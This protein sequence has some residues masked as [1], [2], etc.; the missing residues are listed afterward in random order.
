[1]SSHFAKPEN[2]LSKAQTLVSIGK[3][4]AALKTLQGILSARRYRLWT[5]THEEIMYLY[6]Q[7][8]VGLRRN[9]KDALLQYRMI[10]QPTQ[11]ASLERVMRRYQQ[12]A[13]E[14]ANEAQAKAA[15]ATAAESTV[16]IDVDDLEEDSPESI[17]LAAMSGEGT[18]ERLD[19]QILT[20]WV[21]YLW[22]CY[23]TILE[24][25]RNNG[26]LEL[27]YHQTARAAFNFCKRFQRNMEFRRL[28]EILRNHL[29]TITKFQNQSNA[30]DLNS[31]ETQKLYLETRFQ[32]LKMAADLELW[33]E[34]YR[35]IEDIHENL[36]ASGQVEPPPELMKT[37]YEK[38]SQIFWASS[39][40][41]FHAYSLH[42]CYQLSA[43]ESLA[44]SS[45]LSPAQR[46][47]LASSVVLSALII[48]GNNSSLDLHDLDAI[49]GVEHEG[50]MRLAQL[51]GFKK[52]SPSRA[53]IIAA[54]QQSGVFQ[55]ANETVKTIFRLLE[56]Q[57]GPLTLYAQLQPLFATLRSDASLQ[58]YVAPLEQ[59][60]ILRVLQ[61]LS[62]V[63]KSMRIDKFINLVPSIGNIYAL[64]RLI[65]SGIT[66]EL[67]NLRFDHR[68]MTLIF[69]E[70]DLEQTKLKDQL[71]Q[72]SRKFIS[73]AHT[74]DAASASPADK[75]KE[76]T[77]V[78]KIIQTN[79]IEEHEN[80]FLRQ[81]LIEKR[82]QELE[83]AQYEKEKRLADEKAA[84]Q[85]ARELEEKRRLQEESVKREE[86]RL[87]KEQF[88]RELRQKQFLADEMK[89]KLNVVN[90]T[91]S[92]STAKA[93]KMI[94]ALTSDLENID[95]VQLMR[96]QEEILR[97][98]QREIERRRKESSRRIDYTVRA[99]RAEERDMLVAKMDAQ[100]EEEK[101]QFEAD[102]A[103]YLEADKAAHAK[104]LQDKARLCG[105]MTKEK[106][107][108]FEKLMQRRQSIYDVE[109][110]KQDE[111]LAI[112]AERRRAAE[113][114]R[115][116]EEEA[117]EREREAEAER[118]RKK[119]EEEDRREAE[120]A[121]A[122]K[123]RE[124]ERLER[125]RKEN[126]I[127]QQRAK[128]EEEAEQRER[129]R[130]AAFTASSQPRTGGW[131]RAA[132]GDRERERERERDEPRPERDLGDFRSR[133]APASGE[134]PPRADAPRWGRRDERPENRDNFRRDERP[135]NRDNFRRDERSENRDN[136][137]R[138]DRGGERDSFR[139]DDRDRGDF[140][141][142]DRDRGDFRRDG[143]PRDNFRRDD[144]E[145]GDFRRGGD[146][147]EPPSRDSF[148]SRAAPSSRDAPNR[149]R[150]WG[151]VRQGAPVGGRSDNRD[152]RRRD[153]D[154][155]KPQ[156]SP[157]PASSS[158]D[159]DDGF[160]EVKKGAG[161]R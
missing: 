40:F 32:Q 111:R 66:S 41:L 30:I 146:D 132:G 148:G 2:A 128:L 47:D 59:L 107:L 1:M 71:V 12:T 74:L 46:T 149:D 51:L 152:F 120:L 130:R 161:R 101:E 58:K 16:S 33:Q 124:E 85:R 37:Y 60:T 13:E 121:L 145:R 153:E 82:K 38:L 65:M 56:N 72:V 63:F 91:T 86:E 22:E 29:I 53:R 93:E 123:K 103:K 6:I 19:R 147:R 24:T 150:D 90:A 27:L 136:F 77:N 92:L 157:A 122:R 14:K 117:R 96:A 88:D 25:L 52:E 138:D 100:R 70:S 39:N 7:V 3:P 141:R 79:L 45:A 80:V 87:K 36:K 44:D 137:R 64:E 97:S 62:T 119:R 143:P 159:A 83:K 73:L 135:E 127:L 154:A 104:A 94:Q 118:E 31:P 139:R 34:A 43:Q 55:D 9:V 95:K 109:K 102:F 99:M 105:R 108:F 134:E 4:S 155:P 110:A 151:S 15:E 35:T 21:K 28:C 8:A 112:K 113:E 49:A 20:P 61:Q 11:M 114:R 89:K 10:C 133:A 69:P 68:T 84:A 48:T 57:F 67:L 126:E 131:G 156:S 75:L 116:K 23:R 5:P 17:M 144:R 26:R 158:P 140:R 106:D 76:R 42:S 125:Q 115:R 142:D 98:Q 54:I 160:T 18:K 50:N 81:E 78:F 129:E